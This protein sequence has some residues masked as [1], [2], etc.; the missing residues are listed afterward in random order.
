MRNYPVNSPEAAARIV[1][2][3]M[4][5]DGHLSPAELDV[6]RRSG[7]CE[8]LGLPPDRLQ[9]VLVELCEDLLH[10]A[11]LEWSQACKV[12]PQ[13]LTQLMAEIDDPA[14]RQRVLA[15]CRQVADADHHLSDGEQVLLT[16]ASTQWRASGG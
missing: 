16:H 3:T 5:A 9:A 10:G 8:T 12:G 15:L 6:L 4:L 7:G 2:L 11:S 14:L 1:A 13:A